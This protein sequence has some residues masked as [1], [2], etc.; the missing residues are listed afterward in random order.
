MLTIFDRDQRC[1][2][3]AF[4]QV[5]GLTLGGGLALSDLLAIKARG[6][7]ESRPLVRDKSVIFL[8]LHGGPSQIETFDPKMTA[9]VEL[10]SATGEIP[11]NV[12]G[13]SFGG[14]FPRLARLADKVT[15]IRSFVTGDGNHDIKPVVGRDT[16]G[17]NLGAIYSRVAGQNRPDNGLPTNVLLLPR[18]VDPSTRPGTMNFGRFNSTGSLRGTY[19]PFDPS[20]GG[21]VQN[22][23]RLAMPLTQLDDRRRLLGE[24][25]RV[26]WQLAEQDLLGG[27]DRVHGRA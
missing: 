7:Q 15:V 2:R 25:D 10:R 16:F 23:M 17:A 11:T 27:M 4:L 20:S 19:A 18:A 8:F 21:D 22:D 9:P 3:R 14:T 5:G 13:V 26:Q 24:L 12:P 1:C 6:E